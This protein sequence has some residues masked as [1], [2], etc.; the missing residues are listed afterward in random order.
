[1]GFILWISFSIHVLKFFGRFFGSA[2]I[3]HWEAEDRTKF[4][5]TFPK[6][7]LPY[8]HELPHHF[9]GNIKGNLRVF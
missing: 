5:D 8:G 1:M 3:L 2:P 6:G 9:F 7:Y 4:K